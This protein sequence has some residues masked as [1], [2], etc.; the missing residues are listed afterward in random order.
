MKHLL[1]FALSVVAVAG[2]NRCAKPPGDDPFACS[3]SI[4]AADGRPSVLIVGDSISIGYT[5]HLKDTLTAYDVEHNPCNAMNT[6]NTRRRVADWLSARPHWDAV[7]W[8]NG[9]WDIADWSAV[10]DS[11]YETNLH[12][13]AQQLKAHSS[14]VIF[15]LTTEVP[16]GT[17]GRRNADVLTKN[18]IAR[19]VM[20]AEGIPVVDLYSVSVTLSGQHPGPGDVHYTAAGS[21]TLGDEVLRALSTEG[22]R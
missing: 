10:S 14:V 20:R 6:V 9:L 13:I 21:Q 12:V 2:C 7:V 17:E 1:Y 4:P 15:A 19:T 18:A 16:S 22:V 3:M 5:P 11:A 8:N